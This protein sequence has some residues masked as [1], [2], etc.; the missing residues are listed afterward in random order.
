MLGAE[1]SP[2]Q[3]KME[4]TEPGQLTTAIWK[5]ST[6]YLSGRVKSIAGANRRDRDKC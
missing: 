5:R 1:T 4:T 3:L 6:R 2:S